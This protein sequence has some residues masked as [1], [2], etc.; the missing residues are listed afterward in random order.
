VIVPLA[1]LGPAGARGAL[2]ALF[3]L[4]GGL[5]FAYWVLADPSYEPTDSL[6]DPKY[7][8]L[9][10]GALL[11]LAVALPEYASL[12]GTR[13]A[14]R[15]SALPAAGAALGCIAN[16]VE[17]GLGLGWAFWLFFVGSAVTVIGLLT[18]TVVMAAT[19]RGRRRSLAL[20]PAAT[21]VAVVFYVSI[22]G[23]LML[24]AWLG[25]GALAL[26]AGGEA[27]RSRSA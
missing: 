20:V 25:A 1:G 23:P 24:A 16:F 9:F 5:F 13:A 27:T 8:L 2:G 15:T 11:A 3:T 12:S 18:L 6:T 22:G 17:D 26:A 21:L 7:V 14:R 10:S 19:N 4:V